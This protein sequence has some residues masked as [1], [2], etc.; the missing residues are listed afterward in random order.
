MPPSHL[1]PLKEVN[2]L[3]LLLQLPPAQPLI[4]GLSLEEHLPLL[5]A[6]MQVP[7]GLLQ[8]LMQ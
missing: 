4:S 2:K 3:L 8:V 6:K 1:E 7:H 5:L